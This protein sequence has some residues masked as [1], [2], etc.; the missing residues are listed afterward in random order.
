MFPRESRKDVNK[1]MKELFRQWKEYCYYKKQKLLFDELRKEYDDERDF[2]AEYGL[3]SEYY[4]WNC[5]YHE[6]DVHK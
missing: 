3:G 2:A 4:C 1:K 5:K 6:C